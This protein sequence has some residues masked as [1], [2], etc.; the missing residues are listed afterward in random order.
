MRK[1]NENKLDL[2]FLKIDLV[3]LVQTLGDVGSLTSPDLT[4]LYILSGF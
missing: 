3:G 4:I 2:K 1:V